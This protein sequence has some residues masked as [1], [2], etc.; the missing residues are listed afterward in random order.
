M[1]CKQKGDI[2]SRRHDGLFHEVHHL[3]MIVERQPEAVSG[4]HAKV[5][6]LEQATFPTCQHLY[7]W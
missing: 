4:T 5:E 6:K 1:A 2:V 7:G 3:Q